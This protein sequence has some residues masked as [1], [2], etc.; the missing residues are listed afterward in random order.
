MPDPKTIISSHDHMGH[1][2]GIAK[3]TPFARVYPKVV[4][5]LLQAVETYALSIRKDHMTRSSRPHVPGP[6]VPKL[7]ITINEDGYPSLPER[8]LDICGVRTEHERLV[9]QYLAQH[10]SMS[11]PSPL[12]PLLIPKC[13]VSIREGYR[14]CP[15]HISGPGCLYNGPEGIFAQ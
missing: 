12:F 14:G 2:G 5:G 9:K 4:E 6:D 8:L 3:P 13:R 11:F 10:Y 7:C 15:I 1:L